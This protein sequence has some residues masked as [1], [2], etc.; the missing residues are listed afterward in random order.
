MPGIY[1]T[2]TQTLPTIHPNVEVVVTFRGLAIIDD[3]GNEVDI[4]K[5]MCAI[6]RQDSDF[7]AYLEPCTIPPSDSPRSEDQKFLSTLKDAARKKYAEIR[8]KSDVLS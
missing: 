8:R 3:E 2:H 1:F 5:V 4:K 7:V 6:V